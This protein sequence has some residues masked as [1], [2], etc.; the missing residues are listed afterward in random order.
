MS[1]IK[2]MANFSLEKNI[3]IFVNNFFVNGARNYI[4]K[5]TQE[6]AWLSVGIM[7]NTN[8]ELFYSSKLFAGMN[9]VGGGGYSLGHGLI[10]GYLSHSTRQYIEQAVANLNALPTEEIIFYH[11]ESLHGLQLARE[12][13]LEIRFKPV[14]LLE[15]LLETANNNQQQIQPLKANAAVQL[16]C[17]SCF[18]GDRNKLIDKLF[19]LLGVKRV[20][21]RY[22]YSDR[23]CCGARGYFG[24]FSGNIQ[25]DADYSDA[26]IHKNLADAKEAGA[27]Y[28]VTLCP[29]CY[30]SI[31]PMAREV[32]LIPVQVE[33]LTSLAIDGELPA[34]GLVFL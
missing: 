25:I 11:D 30:A 18:G 23:L 33:D 3:D 15:W 12:I 2:E 28:I 21:R 34:G 1:N 24:L 5:T 10:H 32:G 20:K 17:S 29:L 31:A 4:R 16:P 13:G 27:D 8:P 7:E 22:D 14:S 19:G 9:I 26:L 6:A